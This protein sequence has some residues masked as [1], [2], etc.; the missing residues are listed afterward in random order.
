M[1]VKTNMTANEE[2]LRERRCGGTS[3]TYKCKVF[4]AVI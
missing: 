2:Y 4:K 3:M 1:A